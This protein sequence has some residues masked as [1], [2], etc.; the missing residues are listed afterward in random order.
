MAAPIRSPLQLNLKHRGEL[1]DDLQRRIA[2]ALL[3]GLFRLVSRHVQAR[4][5]E[6]AVL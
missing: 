1:G 3:S 4:E 2:R 5:E 6:F